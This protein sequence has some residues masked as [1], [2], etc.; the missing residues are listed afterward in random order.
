[1]R[2]LMGTIEV[3]AKG[4]KQMNILDIVSNRINQATESWDQAQLDQARNSS[5]TLA[6]LSQLLNLSQITIYQFAE[7]SHIFLVNGTFTR[8]QAVEIA[9]ELSGSPELVSNVK[10]FNRYLQ[11]KLDREHKQKEAKAERERLAREEE[12][13]RKEE[14][15]RLERKRRDQFLFGLAF[16]AVSIIGT[17]IS[18]PGS[19]SSEPASQ[20]VHSSIH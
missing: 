13:K 9:E 7:M 16:V 17:A 3:S 20:A 19:F 12:R 11:E 8:K 14:A 5:I 1:M 18:E 2:S 10:Y 15:D 6:E 4:E